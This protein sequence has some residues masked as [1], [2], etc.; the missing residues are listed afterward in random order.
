MTETRGLGFTQ[1]CRGMLRMLSRL[2][3]RACRG[4]RCEVKKPGRGG[5][6]RSWGEVGGEMEGEVAGSEDGASQ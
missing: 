5:E 3:P 2:T 6:E 1:V 4:K